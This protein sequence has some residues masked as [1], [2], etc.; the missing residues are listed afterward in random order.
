MKNWTL[1]FLASLLLGGCS[2]SLQPTSAVDPATGWAAW[3]KSA[4]PVYSGTSRIVSDPSVIADEPV[5]RL[6][7]TS[8]DFTNAAGPHASISLATSADSLKWAAVS[9][10]ASGAVF[11]GEILRGRD[12]EWDE[13]LETPFLI[14]TP[15]GYNLYYSG[16]RDGIDPGEPAK[17]LPAS[18]GLATSTDGVTFTRVQSEPILAPTPGSFDADAIYSPDV[19]PYQGG[20]LM[21]YA[22]HCY[23]N[24]P[25][26]PGVRI[27]S[28]TSPDGITWT[29]SEEPLLSPKTPP[30]WMRDSVAE[31]AIILGPDG[32]LYLF[33]TGVRDSDHVIGVARAASLNAAWDIDPKP[34]V[35]PTAGG[36]DETGDTGPTVLL[37]N[38]A[39]RMWFTGTNGA[40]Q[41]AIGYAE[42]PWPLRRAD[43]KSHG[44]V[45]AIASV[46]PT[47]IK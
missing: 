28:A 32:Y 47:S 8:V 44:P 7:Y 2:S 4:S 29:K 39:V 30:E 16:Y 34:I 40:S 35:A 45:F 37:E 23:T 9:S 13:N 1:L 22:G 36:F 46:I 18:L 43:A 41:Y 26:T 6:A 14:K 31:P 12:G 10:A 24:C 3:A 38:G 27:M 20:Y 42:A 15:N 25:G 19:I 5:F 17:G 11:R 33:F 21:V